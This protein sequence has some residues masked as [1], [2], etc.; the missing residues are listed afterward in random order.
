MAVY[1]VMLVDDEE[2]VIQA[3]MRKIDWEQ[4][5]FTVSGYAHNGI[6]AL[7]LA[8]AHQPD[9]VMTDIK[10][11]YMDGLELAR[12]LKQQYPA[13]KILILSGF[14]EFEYAQEAIRLE[15]E[16]Y[17]LKPINSG[18]LTD[19]FTRIK[20]ALDKEREERR[21]AQ[22]LQNYYMES[23]PLLQENFYASLIEGRI[24]EDEL[25]KYMRDY[26]IQLT[27]PWYCVSVIHTSQTD[28]PDGISP[29]LM[30]V[31]IRQLIQERAG[32]ESAKWRQKVF[33]YLGNT[34]VINQL[35]S[36][37]QIVELTDE[38]NRFCRLA[39]KIFGAVV[40]IGIG[41]PCA[42]ITGI[43]QSYSGAREALSYRVLY[44]SGQSIRIGEIAPQTAQEIPETVEGGLHD[45]F[46]RIRTDSPEALEDAVREFLDR[47][48]PAQGSLQGYHFFLMDMI[49]ELHR[50]AVNHH[51]D[52][53]QMFGDSAALFAKVQ[54]MEPQELSRWLADVCR[55][56]Q[57]GIQVSRTD[58]T[59]SLVARA[60][61]YIRDNYA[62]Q[63]LTVDKM[64]GLLGLSAAYFSTVFK[65][66]TG[67]TFI[68]YLTDLRMETAVRLLVEQDLKTYVIARQVGYADPNYFSYVFKKYYGVSPSKYK[69]ENI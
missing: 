17:L 58:T 48:M 7:E 39:N 11:P 9:V 2:D 14:D 25:G 45:V 8:E 27:G 66:E 4:L 56:M 20:A 41:E 42:A 51:L 22:M 65:K 64:C 19:V 18:E 69:S 37:D 68:G 40:T 26:Q 43:A 36:Q 28:T 30:S 53:A 3:M 29:V 50:F 15:A 6:E 5:G 24:P 49:S 67:K 60:V 16:E 13:V 52:A 21:S 54:Q 10:M 38:A 57:Q 33:S 35:G 55:K 61:E 62:D 47:R 12:Q 31:S 59:K 63:D 46:R 34:V 32:G 44:G 1:S 23:L